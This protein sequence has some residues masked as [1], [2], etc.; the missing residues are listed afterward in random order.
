MLLISRIYE[1]LNYFIYEIC[2]I[3]ARLR[4]KGPDPGHEA[5]MSKNSNVS[6]IQDIRNIKTIHM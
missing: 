2:N 5:R 3:T 1:T 4:T 6:Y